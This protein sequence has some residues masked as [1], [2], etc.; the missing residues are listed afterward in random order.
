MSETPT[1]PNFHQTRGGRL[2]VKRLPSLKFFTQ[3][4]QIPGMS[5]RSA[6]QATPHDRVPRPGDALY[7]STLRVSFKVDEDMENYAG[8]ASWFIGV[9]APDSPSQYEAIASKASIGEGVVSDLTVTVADSSWNHA[10]EYR[11]QDAFPVSI[12]G[13]EYDTTE[14]AVRVAS[15]EVNF[16]FR[17][18]TVHRKVDD[19]E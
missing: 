19:W 11:F 16:Q 2:V 5:I 12:T 9:S 17:H 7:R 1:N 6:D 14:E 10:I 4:I 13:P 15:A 8:L 3:K 18:F